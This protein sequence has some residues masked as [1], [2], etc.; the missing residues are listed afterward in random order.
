MGRFVRKGRGDTVYTSL[1]CGIPL[2]IT[3]VAATTV[4]I[5][6]PPADR[7][8]RLAA[9]CCAIMGLVFGIGFLSLVMPERWG[10]PGRLWRWCGWLIPLALL[11]FAVIL[12]RD[13]ATAADHSSRLGG[14]VGSVIFA[15]ALLFV[16][17]LAAKAWLGSVRARRR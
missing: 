15:V 2:L 10:A 3:G 4:S 6:D 13:P 9:G 8:E 7:F 16:A 17:G 1:M 12:L 5:L 11:P 14:S